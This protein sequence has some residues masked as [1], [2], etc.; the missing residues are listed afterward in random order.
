MHPSG[1]RVHYAVLNERDARILR[2][3]GGGERVH[4]LPNAT[5]ALTPLRRSPAKTGGRLFLYPTRAIRRKNIGEFLL[6]SAIAEDG[7][8]FAATLAPTAPSDREPYERWIHVADELKLPVEWEASKKAPDRYSQL[9]EEAD[10]LVTTSVAEGF[11]LAFLEP[12]QMGRPLAGRNLPEIT[13]DFARAGLKLDHLYERLDVPLEWVGEERF[14]SELAAKLDSAHAAYGRQPTADATAR[15]FA[16]AVTDGRVDVGRL[17]ERMQERVLRRLRANPGSRDQLKPPALPI[18]DDRI[19]HNARVVDDRFNLELY[20]ERL[21]HLYSR[22]VMP[23]RDSVSLEA[24]TI[25]D[26]FLK[27]ER[28][29]LLRT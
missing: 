14:R 23:G 7:D 20:G 25:L 28:F 8:R 16:A 22:A 12:W 13:S 26:E 4:L 18:A 5:P 17:D 11:G 29:C 10:A 2:A 9:L 6:W 19:A 1:P 27:P 21:A 15:A 3:A 24:E